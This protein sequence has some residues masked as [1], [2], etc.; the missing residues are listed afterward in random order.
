MPPEAIEAAFVVRGAGAGAYGAGALTGVVALDELS[1]PGALV[2]DAYGGELRQRPG[3]GGGRAGPGRGGPLP[4][5][6]RRAF[7]RLDPGARGPRRGRRPAD[8]RRLEPGGALDRAGRAGGRGGAA[9]AYDERRDSGLVGAQSRAPAA[10]TSAS[11]SRASRGKACSAGGPR[12]GRGPAT[13]EN[14]SVAVA[15]DRSFDHARQQPVRHA[16][17]GLGRQRRAPRPG[18]A[19]DLGGRR[20]RARGASG[21]SRER[22]RNLGAGFTRTRVAGGET[23]VAGAYGEVARADGPWLLTGGVRLDAWSSSDGH[24]IERD[25]ATGLVSFQDLPADREGVVPTARAGLRREPA[26]GHL[27]PRRGLFRLPPADA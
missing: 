1:R 5:G 23:L 27:R 4:L 24:R 18:R 8:A 2:A 16:G 17:G 14:S 13:F 25:L 22:F 6:L 21:E 9:S 3:R 15:P 11:P 19:D 26:P 7:R 10:R 20:R 12:A